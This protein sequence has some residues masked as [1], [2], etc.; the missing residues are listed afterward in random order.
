MNSDKKLCC[1]D[2]Y[3]FK[4]D[5]IDGYGNGFCFKKGTP[6]IDKSS[7]S[8]LRTSKPLSLKTIISDFFKK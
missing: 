5:N 7:C 8:H 1:K 4:Q 3:F 6:T 2:C